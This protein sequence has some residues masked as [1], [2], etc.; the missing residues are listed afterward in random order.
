VTADAMLAD[1][2]KPGKLI[3]LDVQRAIGTLKFHL[4]RLPDDAPSLLLPAAID[5]WRTIRASDAPAY[6]S[7]LQ[8]VRRGGDKI[9][10]DLIE[11][12]ARQGYARGSTER[13]IP[14]LVGFRAFVGTFDPPQWVLEL[15]LQR[16][17][18]YPLTRL[19]GH[20]KTAV[21]VT[22]ALLIASGRHLGTHRIARERVAF[23]REGRT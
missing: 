14:R 3:P 21:M 6:V 1:G 2:E 8:L 17:Y 15:I 19:W 20:G 5:A 9:V 4:N 7:L 13:R 16:G 22:L 12:Y 23:L 10:A 18:V 11:E